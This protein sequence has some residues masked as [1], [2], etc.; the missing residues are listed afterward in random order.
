MQTLQTPIGVIRETVNFVSNYFYDKFKC[1][2]NNQKNKYL[3]VQIPGG[4]RRTWTMLN[5]MTR[6]IKPIKNSNIKF[7]TIPKCGR[8]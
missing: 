5:V 6:E 4:F 2:E 1:G 7:L 8:N 3:E